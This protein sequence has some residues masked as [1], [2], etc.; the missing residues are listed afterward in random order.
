M[1]PNPIASTSV[2]CAVRTVGADDA[3]LLKRL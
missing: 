3:A 2:P 1:S